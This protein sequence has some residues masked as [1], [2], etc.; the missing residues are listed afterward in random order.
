MYNLWCLHGQYFQSF[1]ASLFLALNLHVA[2]H[3]RSQYVVH[4]LV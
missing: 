2:V 3:L 4:I 1:K